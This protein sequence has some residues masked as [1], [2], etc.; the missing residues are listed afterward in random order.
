[1]GLNDHDLKHVEQIVELSISRYREAMREEIAEQFT[2]HQTAVETA[3]ENRV[4]RLSA[5]GLLWLAGIGITSGVL[6]SAAKGWL[7][8]W[9]KGQ[10]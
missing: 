7:V 10:S 4:M 8:N 6:G 3:V 5:R 9:I 2:K 1:M